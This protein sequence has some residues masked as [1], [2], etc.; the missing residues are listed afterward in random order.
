MGGSSTSTQHQTQSNTINPMQMQQ[1]QDNYA[2]AQNA[3]S[4]LTPY[5]GQITAGFNPTQTQAQG[6]LSGVATDPRYQAANQGAI[7]SV[8]GLLGANPNTTI[9]AQPYKASTYDPAQLAGT[10]LS[11]Y[12]NPYTKDVINASIAQNERARQTANV[13]DN[14]QATAAGAFGGSR[15]GVANALTNQLYDQNDQTNIANLNSAN[16]GQ[17]QSAALGDIGA[18]NTAGQFNAGVLN[19]AAQFN[20]GQN[21]NAQQSSIQ[22]ALAQAG[23]KLNAAG[24][25]EQLNQGALQTAAQQGGILSAV[26]DAQQQ[27]Q[28]QELTNAYNAYTQGQQLTMAQ[29]QL[30]NQALGIIPL[31]QTNTTDGT[32][33]TKSNPGAMGILSGIAGLGLAAASGGSSLGLTGGLSALGGLFG[34]SLKGQ[35]SGPSMGWT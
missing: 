22:N 30:L 20:S 14:Q 9:T 27:Q 21:V 31:E 17:A 7:S 28:Q 33:T 34:G 15:S 11:P 24:Q 23:F 8:Q 29:Q 13:Y 16:F 1:Y 26:G 18:R 25:L 19:N 10:D 3:A 12:M 4:T 2:K 6:V 35:S 32:T 5:Q